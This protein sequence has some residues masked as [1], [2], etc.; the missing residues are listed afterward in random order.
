MVREQRPSY[1]GNQE[2]QHIQES[3]YLDI[4]DSDTPII[5]AADNVLA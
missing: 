3:R 5:R 4:E 2:S 1:D